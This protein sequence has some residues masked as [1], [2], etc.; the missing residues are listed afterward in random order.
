[1]HNRLPRHATVA[2]VAVSL[3][4]VAATRPATAQL[5]EIDLFSQADNAAAANAQSMT[6]FA[7]ATNVRDSKTGANATFFRLDLRPDL[8]FGRLRVGLKAVLLIGNPQGDADGDSSTKILTEDGEEWDTLGAYLR[9]VRYVQ[10]ATPRAPFY[11]RYGELYGVRMANGF[12]MEGYTN[13]DRRGL[14]LNVNQPGWGVHTILNNI[15]QPELFGARVYARPLELA[16]VETPLLSKITVGTTHLIDVDPVPDVTDVTLAATAIDI[17][18]PIIDRELLSLRLYDELAWLSYPELDP[19]NPPDTVKGNATG[20][21][22]D[23]TRLHAKL[24]YRT[25]NRGF[26]PSIFGS[27]YE[28]RA[29]TKGIGIRGPSDTTAT[30]GYFGAASLDLGTSVL[31]SGTFEDYDGD[32]PVGDPRLALQLIETD[33]VEQLDFRAYYTKRGIHSSDDESFLEDLVDL[34]EKSLFAMQIAY[35]LSGPLQ[36]V[37]TREFRFREKADEEGFETIKKT[38][39]QIGFAF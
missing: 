11:A 17:T 6:A 15:D 33:L 24:E 16:A 34:D 38:T 10:W 9:A 21:G 5:S 37:A 2:A 28:Y 22:L 27:D 18:L 32:G 26:E 3:L 14:R 39:V 23:L 8:T 20:I 19:V 25:F 36:L 35:N 30:K 31:V 13:L 12:V 29:R 1:M 7:G 4:L